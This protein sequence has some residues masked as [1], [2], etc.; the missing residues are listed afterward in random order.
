[1][2]FMGDAAFGMT[3]MEVETAARERL[4]VLTVLINNSGMC[5]YPRGYPTA[6]Q[7]FGFANLRGDYAKLAEA[8]GAYSE[9]VEE[10][11]EVAPALKRA[12]KVTMD[13]RPALLEVIT[14]QEPVIS[15]FSSGE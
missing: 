14:R 15:R 12:G 3:G 5:G 6:V 1:V 4:G 13:G 7:Q 8:L 2:N 10:P 9:R 11:A